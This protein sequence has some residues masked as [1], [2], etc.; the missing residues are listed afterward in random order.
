PGPNRCAHDRYAEGTHASQTL[1][2]PRSYLSLSRWHSFDHLCAAQF[3][4]C[5]CPIADRADVHGTSD[6]PLVQCSPGR[7]GGGVGATDP[8][9][10]DG[11]EWYRNDCP[12]VSGD[13]WRADSNAGWECN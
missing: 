4:L 1:V 12:A 7:S 3:Q 5:P 8:L 11:T 10:G 13:G 9:G 6:T 2:L